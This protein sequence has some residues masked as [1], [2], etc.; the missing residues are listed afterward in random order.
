MSTRPVTWRSADVN[1]PSTRSSSPTTAP[2]ASNRAIGL[3]AATVQVKASPAEP[4]SAPL[5]LEPAASAIPV[6]PLATHAGVAASA[7][8]RDP[9]DEHDT[10]A[11][12]SIAAN[13]IGFATITSFGHQKVHRGLAD[14]VAIGVRGG[15]MWPYRRSQMFSCR[16]R[17]ARDAPSTNRFNRRWS[18]RIGRRRRRSLKGMSRFGGASSVG[19]LATAWP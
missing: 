2:L 1:P 15:P 4:A 7:W 19:G 17:K 13:G 8:V 11:A 10:P 6:G 12:I 14:P 5:E 9:D 16:S 18:R 3:G